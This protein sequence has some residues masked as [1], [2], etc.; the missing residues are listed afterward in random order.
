VFSFTLIINLSVFQ[1]ILWSDRVVYVRNSEQ[2]SVRKVKE[3]CDSIYLVY[4][5]IHNILFIKKLYTISP[6]SHE[7]VKYI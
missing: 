2:M 1:Q 3:T 4:N 5:Y 7:K 6:P